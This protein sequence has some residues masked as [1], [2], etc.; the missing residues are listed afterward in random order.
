MGQTPRGPPDGKPQ[1]VTTN[2]AYPCTNDT[3]A[4][5]V[6]R[7]FVSVALAH[8]FKVAGM[9]NAQ[10]NSPGALVP[11]NYYMAMRNV[12]YLCQVMVPMDCIQRDG[13]IACMLATLRGLNA[14]AATQPA[15]LSPRATPPQLPSD[16]ALAP[17][18]EGSGSGSDGGLSYGERAG[19]IAGTVIGGVAVLTA[20][21]LAAWWSARRRRQ[22]S[23]GA[24]RTASD[25]APE[26]RGPGPL[27][28]PKGDPAF[29]GTV[30]AD[31]ESASTP[32][33]EPTTTG[34][35]SR[36]LSQPSQLSDAQTVVTRQTPYNEGL[37]TNACLQ[38]PEDTC[39]GPGAGPGTG[40]A[41]ADPEAGLSS[42]A[43]AAAEGAAER[44]SQG[45][46]PWA[47]ESDAVKLLPGPLLGKGAFAVVHAGVYRG[48]EVAVKLLLQGFG[49]QEGCPEKF[50]ATL[51]SELEI[52]A[53][54]RHPNVICLLAAC[55]DPPRPF[56]V[57]EKMETSLDKLLY[58]RG[59][60][61][62]LPLAMVLHIAI[63]ISKGLEYLH[64]TILHRDLKPANVLI[65]D[66]WGPKPVVKLSDFG[67]SRIRASVLHTAT[68]DAG[69]PAYLAPEC[70]VV[71]PAAEL[72]HKAD[73]WSFGTLLWECLAGERPWTGATG[74]E[75]AITVT[76]RKQRLPLPPPWHTPGGSEYTRWP[77]RL[78]RLIGDC[79]ES[80]PLRRP[81]AAELVKRL[82]LVEEARRAGAL[83][84]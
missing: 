28:L 8:D 78:V 50:K 39:S 17:G 5:L 31:T 24:D 45:N 38:V 80:D 37:N 12:F 40:D 18:P 65:T 4:P 3:S 20:G 26:A 1:N 7:C 62:L 54:C 72:T 14:S 66:P 22:R 68:P 19:V 58:G 21:V 83:D 33:L 27:P 25:G 57:L 32:S 6:R 34:G 15:A 60:G 49:L 43:G 53:R 44:L 70:F 23:A 82:A 67:L 2:L 10:H 46:D 71:E 59:E 35:C 81:A 76:M 9:V 48:Q 55:L 30:G 61:A 41:E 79:F 74:L 75:V 36:I 42:G 11:T 77:F 69:T 64:P 56:M 52:L 51:V 13:P 73:I 29:S 16:F 84:V 63:E 47:V